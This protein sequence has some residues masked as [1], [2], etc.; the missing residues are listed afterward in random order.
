VLLNEKNMADD[1]Q[2]HRLIL[3]YFSFTT[4]KL[5]IESKSGLG[6]FFFFVCFLFIDYYYYYYWVLFPSLPGLRN[7]GL[8]LSSLVLEASTFFFNEIT[9]LPFLSFLFFFL[10]K[11]NVYFRYAC[12]THKA[13]QRGFFY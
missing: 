10:E 6:F 2:R 5:E 7:A 4:W 8:P 9:C 11:N 3:F 1:G 13:R 12:T